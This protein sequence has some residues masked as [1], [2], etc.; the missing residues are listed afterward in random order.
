MLLKW[1]KGNSPDRK[2]LGQD[3]T[4]LAPDTHGTAYADWG[5]FCLDAE[6]RMAYKDGT[7]LYR[8]FLYTKEAVSC[9]QI[10]LLSVRGYLADAI[11]ATEELLFSQQYDFPANAIQSNPSCEE[12]KPVARRIDGM[13]YRVKVHGSDCRGMLVEVSGTKYY[14]KVEDALARFCA[15]MAMDGYI[16]TSVT[17]V[18]TTDNATPKVSVLTSKAYKDEIK[19]LRNGGAV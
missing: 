19:R 1:K 11:K 2:A 14:D 13:T 17:E 16:I 18:H 8:V 6:C 5:I 4:E 3:I 10:P 15:K 12:V 7:R 9:V